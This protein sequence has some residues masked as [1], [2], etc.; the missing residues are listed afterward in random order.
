MDVSQLAAAGLVKRQSDK[1][2]IL[3]AKDRRRERAIEDAEDA[4]KG[5][6]VHPNDVAFKTAL[7]A[8][9]AFALRYAEAGGGNAGVGAARSLMRQQGWDKD[10]AV[11]KLMA[12]LIQA[13]PVA[14]RIERGKTSAA[15]KFPEF[16]AWHAL[17]YPL[18]GIPA[19]DWTEKQPEVLELEFGSP[20][21]SPDGTEADGD[22]EAEENDEE[23]PEDDQ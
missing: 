4:G 16:R 14:V 6:K 15:A 1:V 2:S 12:A 19:P 13:A 5:G 11:A 8:C 18:F 17:L 21:E 23:E 3:S 9:H 10:S 22:D 7:D 20:E